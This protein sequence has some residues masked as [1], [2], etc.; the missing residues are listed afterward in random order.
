MYDVILGGQRVSKSAHPAS[1]THP[2]SAFIGAAREST[3]GASGAALFEV[4]YVVA[5]IT[6]F[7]QP[8]G[9]CFKDSRK[10]KTKLRDGLTTP[11]LLPSSLVWCA[12]MKLTADAE[13]AT[14]GSARE[15]ASLCGSL[16]RTACALGDLCGPRTTENAGGP[17]AIPVVSVPCP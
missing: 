10:P 13:E 11:P 9:N 5:C 2:A 7:G 6:F 8:C 14:C 16:P 12:G 17:L 15:S 3:R 1:W 4:E